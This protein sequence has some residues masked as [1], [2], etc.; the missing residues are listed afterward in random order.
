MKHRA[1]KVQYDDV[2]EIYKNKTEV[3]KKFGYTAQHI[4]GI[5]KGHKKSDYIVYKEKII[6]IS[7]LENDDIKNDINKKEKRKEYNKKAYIK[8]KIINKEKIIK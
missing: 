7:Y 2:E 8:R 4:H 6:H 5:L 1:I 3:A